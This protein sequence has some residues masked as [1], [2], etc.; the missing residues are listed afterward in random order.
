[1]QNEEF[2][3]RVIVLRSVY[4]KSQGVWFTN[5]T[6][7][8]KTGKYPDCVKPVNSN[9]DMIISDAELASGKVYF[10]ETEVFTLVDGTTYNLDDP[11]EKAVWE[12]VKNSVFIAPARNAKDS[13]GNL[14]IDGDNHKPVSPSDGY[15]RRYGTAELYIE[16][17]GLE[18][19]QKLSRKK[20]VYKAVN[21][22][23]NDE[24]GSEGRLLKTKL[25][26]RYMRGAADADVENYLY[27]IAEKDPE[28]IINLY[29]GGDM[30]LRLLLVEAKEKGVIYRKN[31]LYLF[32]DNTVLGATD[33][34]VIHTF[35]QPTSNNI[36][37]LIKKE[38][39]ADIDTPVKKT[40]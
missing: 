30:S 13:N 9:G 26:G 14:L 6:R 28:K 18:S 11:Y 27:E 36:V 2:D 35:K 22:I 5:P 8:K 16:R 7:D 38:V 10:K 24:R 29:T 33:D 23:L 34:A 3:D 21:Y 4:S 17:P 31:G 40:K 25:L 1:M 20:L 19:I 39:N 12:C 32:G 37:T 15:N